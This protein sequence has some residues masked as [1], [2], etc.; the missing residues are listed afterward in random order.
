MKK[1]IV[2]VSMLAL[3]GTAV[4][5]GNDGRKDSTEV[6]EDR[7][8][9]RLDDRKEDAA[10]FVVEAAN[11]G[12]MEVQMGTLA[13]TKAS[14]PAVKQFAQMMVDDHSKANNELKDLAQQKNIALPTVMGNEYQRKYDNLNEKTGADFDKE[15]MDL[16]VSHHKDAVDRFEEQAEDGKDPE[17]KAWASS[18]VAILRKH[19]QEAERTQEAV[20]NNNNR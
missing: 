19:H 17:I 14:S 10:E 4:S 16:M 7:N 3:L 6:A 8:E 2:Y 18:Q 20:K 11:G 15:Y 9:E 13:T 1:S 12:L 5:C